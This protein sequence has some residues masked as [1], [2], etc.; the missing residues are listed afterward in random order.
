MVYLRDT[1]PLAPRASR[2]RAANGITPSAE[3]SPG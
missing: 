3:V 2:V 1:M